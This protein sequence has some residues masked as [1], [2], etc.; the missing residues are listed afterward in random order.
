MVV[1]SRLAAERQQS[2]A[3]EDDERGTS[4]EEDDR[5]ADPR[6]VHTPANHN[7]ESPYVLAPRS[8]VFHNFLP[9]PSSVRFNL[10]NTHA[11]ASALGRSAD[12]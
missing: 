7:R 2:Q 10:L 9:S 12:V 1:S 6:A 8:E 5:L 3:V 4:L 11:I